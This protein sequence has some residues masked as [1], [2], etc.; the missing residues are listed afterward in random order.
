MGKIFLNTFGCSLAVHLSLLFNKDVIIKTFDIA[1]RHYL[2][3][4]YS[5]LHVKKG[6]NVMNVCMDANKKGEDQNSSAFTEV[7]L[8]V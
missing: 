4:F 6:A 2:C 1:R 8:W 7:V 5:P 3:H